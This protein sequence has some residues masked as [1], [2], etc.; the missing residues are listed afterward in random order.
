LFFFDNGPGGPDNVDV[1]VLGTVQ[2]G[3]LPLFSAD[4][5]TETDSEILSSRGGI[6]PDVQ[7]TDT[8]MCA[9]DVSFQFVEDVGL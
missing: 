7:F 9:F 2:P 3:T 4:E 5:I 8:P 6:V 1:R